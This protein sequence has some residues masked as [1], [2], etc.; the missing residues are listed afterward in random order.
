MTKSNYLDLVI[1]CSIKTI[2][3]KLK[4]CKNQESWRHQKYIEK[5]KKDISEDSRSLSRKIVRHKKRAKSEKNASIKDINNK[6]PIN[7]VVK[8]SK[9]K[10]DKKRKRKSIEKRIEMANSKKDRNKLII[11]KNI[12]EKLKKASL[13]NNTSDDDCL[14]EDSFKERKKKRSV[15][16]TKTNNSYR[17]NRKDIYD[18][19]NENNTFENIE[20][21]ED[22]KRREKQYN[23]NRT[24]CIDGKCQ[25]EEFL[26]KLRKLDVPIKINEKSTEQKMN[27]EE[28]VLN[29]V[30]NHPI[31]SISSRVKGPYDIETI[32]DALKRYPN[33]KPVKNKDLDGKVMSNLKRPFWHQIDPIPLIMGRQDDPTDDN[34]PIN[35][36]MLKSFEQGKLKLEKNIDIRPKIPNP[37]GPLKNM[38]KQN[39]MFNLGQVFGNTMRN[40]VKFKPKSIKNSFPKVD[41]MMILRSPPQDQKNKSL[42][43]VKT[44]TSTVPDDSTAE[45]ELEGNFK[46]NLKEPE[47]DMFPILPKTKIIYKRTNPCV[48]KEVPLSKN[49]F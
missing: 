8:P 23:K 44:N 22:R 24:V 18:L 45:E 12:V 41:S 30:T 10:I 38:I 35:S 2:K 5:I 36:D 26:E 46:K 39:D 33:I 11:K 3:D 9:R 29:H 7:E 1:N 25:D 32:E 19:D 15:K 48:W 49:N 28:L 42:E 40:I 13:I 17:F 16:K 27:I 47:N 37:F 31:S 20:K 34:L 6:Y 21:S 4:E 14:N 43:K